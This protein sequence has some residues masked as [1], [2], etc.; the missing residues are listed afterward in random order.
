MS[1]NYEEK[2]LHEIMRRNYY[3]KSA[4]IYHHAKKVG[5]IGILA[6]PK[7]KLLNLNRN[8]QY[9]YRQVIGDKQFSRLKPIITNYT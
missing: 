2:L 7:T 8:I 1:R 3:T 5:I 6:Y 9:T 4:S